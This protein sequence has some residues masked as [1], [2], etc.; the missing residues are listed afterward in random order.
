MKF[1]ILLAAML[2]ASL[3]LGCSS[4]KK[5]QEIKAEATVQEAGLQLERDPRL[6]G[7][8]KPQSQ[9]IIEKNI[10]K[11]DASENPLFGYWVG[12]FGKNKINIA[13]SDIEGDSIYGHSVC[14]GN[15]RPIKGTI[16]SFSDSLF[17]IKMFEPGDDK[18]DGEFTFT[19]DLSDMSLSGSWAPY[20][21]TVSAKNYQ[22]E[23]RAFQYDRKSGDYPET[24]SEYL[25]P[26]YAMNLLPE[27]IELR[28]NEIYARHGYSFQNI[29]IRRI[30]DAK[31][32]Y[33][34]MSI[35][36][37]DK[38]TEVE[39]HNIDMM[40]NYEEYYDDYYDSYGR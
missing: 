37:R 29:K 35:D 7:P 9:K 11:I 8:A 15:F 13:I 18:Y 23:K 6:I 4:P 3:F 31:D 1:N 33:I 2:M 20:K 36:V 14:A 10:Y 5:K 12:A 26:A 30:F 21:N 16:K 34:P 22:L 24:S 40:Y 28:R 38:L 25:E 19:I 39:A 27:E 17:A 32:W